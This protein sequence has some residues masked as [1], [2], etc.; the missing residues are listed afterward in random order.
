MTRLILEQLTDEQREIAAEFGLA[1]FAFMTGPAVTSD[2]VWKRYH[3]AKSRLSLALNG[4]PLSH[5]GS[6]AR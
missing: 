3:E 1:A 5:P 6:P 2:A 4:K